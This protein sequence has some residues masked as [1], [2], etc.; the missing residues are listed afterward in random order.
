M[1]SD[2][3]S[4]CRYVG[5]SEWQDSTSFQTI[6]DALGAVVVASTVERPEHVSSMQIMP[7]AAALSALDLTP[8]LCRRPEYRSHDALSDDDAFASAAACTGK[9]VTCTTRIRN[10]PMIVRSLGDDATA[11][12]ALAPSAIA[13]DA[14]ENASDLGSSHAG[15]AAVAA[16]ELLWLTN[17]GESAGDDETRGGDGASAVAAAAA[18]LMACS[19]SSA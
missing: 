17:V 14:G 13:A 9:S 1:A 18:T 8:W 7:F 6:V 10:E 4:I 12:A 19:S 2:C 11:A 3:Q 5:T 15:A 16:A